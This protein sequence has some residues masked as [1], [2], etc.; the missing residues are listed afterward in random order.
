MDL[1]LSPPSVSTFSSIVTSALTSNPET[2][3]GLGLLH[4]DDLP[5]ENIYNFGLLQYAG[6]PFYI[7][8]IFGFKLS[9]LLSYLRI[10]N[11]TIYRW[12]TISIIALCTMFHLS[13]LL[14]QINLCT[15]VR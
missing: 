4:L 2:K 12:I 1:R 14:V 13:F 7:T 3:W 11:T 9:L 6:A 15:P 5:T 8:S 10:I